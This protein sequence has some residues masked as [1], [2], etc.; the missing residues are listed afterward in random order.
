MKL[1]GVVVLYYP[2]KD[3]VE[4]ISSYIDKLDILYAV[5]NSPSD[6][7]AMFLNEKIKYLPNFEN[8]G[9]AKALNIGAKNATADG[10]EWLLTMDQDSHFSQNSMDR[11]FRH[12]E[13]LCNSC[14]S[15]NENTVE[16]NTVGLI[17]PFHHTLFNTNEEVS[18]I[19][20]PLMVM[21]SGN[22]ISLKAYKDVDGFKDWLFIDAVDFDYCLNL[23]NHGY[24]ILRFNDVVL[25]HLLGDV[26]FKNIGRK[27]I[28][29]LNHS[30][31]R[32]YYIVRNRHY[33]YELYHNDFPEYCDAEI[34][35]TRSDVKSILRCEKQKFKKLLFMFKGYLDY[36][37][38]IKGRMP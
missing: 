14:I 3:T 20:S 10:Y 15:F 17:S 1:A 8:L 13:E 19:D 21:T 38:G 18:G 36:K 35:C 24:E 7:S 26:V 16:S 30:P 6:N 4:N 22:I 23:R 37:K 11:F 2:D 5:D 27:R 9:V 12:L 33:L 25:E 29:S 34:R 32:R 28:Y 31:I